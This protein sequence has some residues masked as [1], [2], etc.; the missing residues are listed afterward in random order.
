MRLEVRAGRLFV[1]DGSDR[2]VLDGWG[3]A[4]LRDGRL[5]STLSEGDGLSWA[6]EDGELRLLL[7][8]V[9]LAPVEVA[10]L[11]PVVS[12]GPVL[13]A[14]C[15]ELH[16]AEVG[17]QSWSR[18]HPL[19]PLRP[20]GLP[21]D[22]VRDPI[23]PE[24]WPDSEVA[25][26]VAVLA[27][28]SP[29]SDALLLGFSRARDYS[30]VVEVAPNGVRA[31]CDVDGAVVRPG[32]TLASEP[33]LIALGREHELLE[34][35]G[36][37]A[38]KRMAARQWPNVPTGWC[39]WYH[40]FT[41]VT[42]ADLRR[43]LQT[44][45]AVR[46]R[47]S[48][49]VFQLDDGYQR[50]VGDWLELN[51]K[52]PSGMPALVRDIRASGFKPGIWLA[53]F[54][55][56]A[57]SHTYLEHPDWVVRGDSGEP[58]V[59]VTN[60]EADNYALDTTHPEALAWVEDV[61]RT[62]CDSW[63]YDY[64][65]IDFIYAG[66]IRGRRHQPNVSAIQAYRRG[67]EA[68]RRA[69]GERFILGCGAPFLPSIGL[70]DGMRIGEDVAPSWRRD[71]NGLGPA[72]TNALHETLLH[73]WMH[74]RWWVND[75]DCLMVRAHDSQLTLAEVQAWAGVVA[76]SGG[77]ALVSDDLSTLE[78][79]RLELLSRL[80]PPLGRAAKALPP[81]V[82]DMPSRLKLRVRRPWGRWWI[83]GLANWTDRTASPTFD[84]GSWDL[85]SGL[86]HVVDLWTGEHLG[87]GRGRIA[88][89]PL[90][91][92]GMHLLSVRR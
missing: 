75:P 44:L 13:G 69:A 33:L 80:F 7:R 49:E 39:S 28:A 68:I 51:E 57:N 71:G 1:L 6:I 14:A 5:L 55:L 62:M 91:P 84:A 8:N 72:M 25:P 38:G 43:N 88:L 89:P 90:A 24:R 48:I 18:P 83:I 20:D 22:V 17:W 67:V 92:H 81:F 70:V 73:G 79:E 30:G 65:K 12:G 36:D 50:A 46:E 64:L 40:F 31:M 78:P 60:W 16:V 4:R 21:I 85:P 3:E 10:W 52:F 77:M 19:Q 26:W 2:T 63:G 74:R 41:W 11:A 56:S 82:D 54:L 87:P 15:R 86:Y 35:Y 59:A 66:A 34:R 61:V 9:G 76:L 37:V 23:V 27:T 58:I 32:E 53:P 47:V 45:Q 42:E 29:R